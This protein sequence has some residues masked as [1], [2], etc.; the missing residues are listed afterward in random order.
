MC[1][2][3]YFISIYHLQLSRSAE[4]QD[5]FKFITQWA[6]SAVNLSY[7]FQQTDHLDSANA[8]LATTE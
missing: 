4:C 5:V 1:Y 2:L 6:G 3:Y 7:S 8:T